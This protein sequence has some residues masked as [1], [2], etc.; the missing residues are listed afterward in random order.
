VYAEVADALVERLVAKARKLTIGPG[1]M[2]GVF[3]GPMHSEAQRAKVEAQVED[4]RASGGEVLVG[5]RRPEGELYE[6][7]WFYEPTLIL[8]P[9]HDSK[10]GVE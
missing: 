10:A 7:G 6:T 4:A 2:D 3:L 8:E 1:T 9:A 5:G